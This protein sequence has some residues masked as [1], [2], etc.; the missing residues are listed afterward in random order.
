MDYLVVI[1][2]QILWKHWFWKVCLTI[3]FR[4]I[5]LHYLETTGFILLH[6]TLI[7]PKPWED[8]LWSQFMDGLGA[9]GSC[10]Y[11]KRSASY[12]KSAWEVNTLNIC[13]YWKC[14]L[15]HLFDSLHGRIILEWNHLPSEFWSHCFWDPVLLWDVSCSSDS[16]DSFISSFFFFLAV[17]GCPLFPIVMK[18]HDT[19]VSVFCPSSC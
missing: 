4:I 9:P 5:V 13:K 7:Y 6:A 19:S 3:L 14:L 8:I 10:L 2:A 18:H 17:L 16:Q 12:E 1:F 11:A 15:L